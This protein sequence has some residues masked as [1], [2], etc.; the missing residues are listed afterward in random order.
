M[1]KWIT[2][3]SLVATIAL[4]C[5]AKVP[6]TVSLPNDAKLGQKITVKVKTAPEIKCKI[7]AQDAG[8]T[9]TLKLLEQK[10]DKAGKAQWT[11]E[12]PKDYKADEMPI[13]VTAVGDKEEEKSTNSIKINR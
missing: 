1:K 2:I 9:Q 6:L 7:E 3:V 5:L 10:A 8:L 12:I 13:I 4:P 11:F